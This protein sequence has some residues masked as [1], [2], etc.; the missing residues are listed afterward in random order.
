MAL[1]EPTGV[2][3]DRL[4][5]ATAWDDSSGDATVDELSVAMSADDT[6]EY[7][8]RNDPSPHEFNEAINR[9]L[10]ET[11]RVVESAL[12]TVEGARHYTLLNA[13]W[14]ERRRDILTVRRRESPNALDNS[15]F[16]LYGRGADAQLQAWTLSGAGSTVTRVDGTYERFA[17]RVTRA[18]ADAALTQTVPIPIIQLSG[19]PVTVFARIR[20]GT[21][22]AASVR[23]SDGS[24]TTS[25]ASHDGGSDW[26]E[27]TATHTIAADAQGPLTV[28]LRVAS[29]DGNADFENVVMV[30][31]ASVPDWLSRYGDQ[32]ARTAAVH[33]TVRMGGSLPVIVVEQTIG[34]GA[35]LLVQSKQPYS[36]L[37]A[38]SGSGGVTDLPFECAV[39]GTIVK[40]A[41]VHSVAKPN[42]ARWER[43][44]AYWMPKYNAWKRMLRE[45]SPTPAEP[46]AVVG[47]V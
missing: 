20:S 34:R 37:T 32:H 30:E 2:A 26:D 23:I 28:E 44:G 13:P 7:Y 5:V 31:G 17:A 19:Q 43:L 1:Y 45:P 39:A 10:S 15:N 29:V 33:A 42:A 38:D 11:E 18:G 35:Q 16:E 41:E 4:R 14:I 46:R 21:A 25:T 3:A 47:G 6:V 40:L 9:V 27:F 36:E 24:G 12:P 22:S 8:L